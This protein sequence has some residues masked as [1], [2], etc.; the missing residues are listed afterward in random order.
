MR[1]TDVIIHKINVVSATILLAEVGLKC[2]GEN[3]CM[4]DIALE[5][6]GQVFHIPNFL[7]NDPIFKKDFIENDKTKEKQLEVL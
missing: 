2:V 6:T 3:D 4:S 5:N 7:I 1:L